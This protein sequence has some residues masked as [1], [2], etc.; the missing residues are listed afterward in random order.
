MHDEIKEL[1]FENENLKNEYFHVEQHNESLNNLIKTL[2]NT[3]RVVEF[4]FYLIF[5]T[6]NL[7]FTFA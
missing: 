7:L 6:K 5:E 4:Y 1:K 3:V 2:E